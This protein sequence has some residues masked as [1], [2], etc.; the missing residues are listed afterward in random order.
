[1][2]KYILK[3]KLKRYYKRHARTKNFLNLKDIHTILVLFDTAHA[4]EASNCLRQLKNLGKTL[5]VC[6]YRKKKDKQDYSGAGYRLISEK[7]AGKWVNNP[8]HSLVRELEK[9]AF[10]AVID[11][12]IRRNTP[13]E[14]VLACTPASVKAGLKKSHFPPYDLAITRLPH[15]KNHP[16]G[17]LAK[18]ILHYLDVIH[19][20]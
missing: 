1:M 9:Q 13:L 2:Y 20:Q 5:T 17:E 11:L 3:Y 7:T 19:S 14:Y 8:I 16:V 15:A 6:A 12:T 10:D 4:E 18:Q